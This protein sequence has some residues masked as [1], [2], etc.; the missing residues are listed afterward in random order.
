MAETMMKLREFGMNVKEIP[1]V[2]R[3]DLKQGLSKLKLTTTIKEYF[4][5][6]IRAKFG[7]L[8]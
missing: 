3:Y 2:Y 7:F 5:L 6:I 1:L 8:K 4:K